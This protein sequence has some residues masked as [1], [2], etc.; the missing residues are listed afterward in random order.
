MRYAEA[1]GM[2]E[3]KAILP[4]RRRW[5]SFSLR[6]LFVFI[7]LLA[8]G[9]GGLSWVITERTQS[10][11]ELDIAARLRGVDAT[12]EFAGLF[13]APRNFN[14]ADE[15]EE[16]AM[17]GTLP[18]DFQLNDAA[19]EQSWWRTSFGNLLGQRV[20]SVAEYE[21]RLT[22]LSPL[23]EL[24]NLKSLSLDR[25]G[26]HPLIYVL[27]NV[28]PQH[29][30]K[31]APLAELK[32]LEYL[33]LKDIVVDDLSP[34][35][36]LVNLKHLHLNMPG[37]R[38]ISALAGLKNLQTLNLNGTEVNDLTP[39]AGLENLREL[40]AVVPHIRD[41]SPLAGLKRLEELKISHTRVTDV[42]PLAGLKS[43]RKLD[44]KYTKV[45]YEDIRSLRRAL[46]KC[47]IYFP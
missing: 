47:R 15:M 12:V 9:L 3:S 24:K 20:V 43:L 31:L 21:G 29:V 8:I 42:S 4:R 16:A 35:A 2:S 19:Q 37:V 26:A 40:T 46:P 41:I 18:E 1:T 45:S 22:D 39:L 25:Y 13:D 34:L 36:G 7:T 6:S 11:R 38:D 33:S 14:L 32:K 30:R 5:L 28:L 27:G 44:L 17:E 10:Q 23:A